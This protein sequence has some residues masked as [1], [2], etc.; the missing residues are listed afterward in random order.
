VYFDHATR[1]LSDFVAGA[2]ED[3]MHYVGVNFGRD[4]AEPETVD[5]RNVVEGDPVPG[6]KGTLKI[7]R[8]IEVGHIFQ[9]GTKYSD[10]LGARVLDQ[11]GA[12]RTMY[13]GCYGIGVS[14]IVGAAIEQNHDERGIILPAPMAPLE[15]NL[16]CS[17]TTHDGRA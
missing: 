16:L 17:H 9:L 7:A 15:V 6:G 10:A 11:D 14:R 2:N 1:L 12:E 3:D 8:G 5:L 13:M 4:L